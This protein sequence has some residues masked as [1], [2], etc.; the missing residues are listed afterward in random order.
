M[1]SNLVLTP[2]S[3]GLTIRGEQTLAN[4]T[5][6]SNFLGSS[7]PNPSYAGQWWIDTSSVNPNLWQRDLNNLNWILMGTYTYNSGNN[8]YSFLA[9]GSSGGGGGGGSTMITLSGVVAGSGT[10][11]ISTTAGSGYYMPTTTDQT[12][13]NN[14][15]SALGY[16][17]VNKAGD[18]LTGTINLIDTNVYITRLGT[19]LLA[20]NLAGGTNVCGVTAS[21]VANG[22][23]DGSVWHQVNT[24]HTTA[25][26]YVDGS[27]FWYTT[28]AAG[29]ATFSAWDA[30]YNVLHSGNFVAGSN[31]VA[32][33]QS[34]IISALGYT[35]I[36]STAINGVSGVCPLDANRLVPLSN[37]PSSLTGGVSYQGFW[38]PSTNTPTLSDATGTN[39][40]MY[41]ASAN[42]AGP[43]SGLTDSSMVNFAVGDTV[44]F[45]GNSHKWQHNSG[46][47]ASV[48][49]VNGATGA[50]TVNAISQLVGDVTT[51]AAIGSQS[52]TA[53]LPTVNSNVGSFNT[54]TVN[55]KG[56]VTSASNTPYLTSNQTI[57]LNGVITGSGTS[58]ITTSAGSGYYFPT[59]TDQTNWNNKQSALGYTPLNPNNNLS[60]ITNAQTAL[61]NLTNVASA[62]NGYVL[63]KDAGT[64][65]VLW[66]AQ[67]GG[68]GGGG[69]FVVTLAGILSG[70][71]TLSSGAGTLTASAA[72]GYYFPTTTDQ[73][74][75][76]AKQAALGYTPLRPSN[77]LSDVLSPSQSLANLGG[78][79]T[80]IRQTI[81]Q[82]PVGTN[83]LPNYFSNSGLTL[84]GSFTAA[85]PFIATS[86]NGFNTSGSVPTSV[87][88][89]IYYNASQT[90]NLNANQLQ[91]V[92]AGQG[93]MVTWG[94]NYVGLASTPP[95]NPATNTIYFDT[96]KQ[97]TYQWSGTTWNALTGYL[98]V[99][100]IT[101]NASTVTTIQYMP[102]CNQGYNANEIQTVG[103]PY[104]V[105][106]GN[107]VSNNG[108]PSF[109]TS[110]SSTS[111]NLLASTVHL[112][113]THS[114]GIQE[115]YMADL[116]ITGLNKAGGTVTSLTGGS[117]SNFPNG[118]LLN[119]Y[120][121]DYNNSSNYFMQLLNSH[122][123][124]IGDNPTLSDIV[125]RPRPIL[126]LNQCHFGSSGQAF[127]TT[128]GTAAAA[129]CAQCD[130][131]VFN[132][133]ND[134]SVVSS[135]AVTQHLAAQTT[136]LN[137]QVVNGGITR[138]DP[139]YPTVSGGI[140]Q[141]LPYC[142]GEGVQLSTDNTTWWNTVTN[143][144]WWATSGGASSYVA[145]SGYATSARRI[146]NHMN[147]AFRT[148]FAT[149]MNTY[150]YANS[151]P[152]VFFDNWTSGTSTSFTPALPWDSGCA[153]TG[154]DLSSS[155]AQTG[156]AVLS[157]IGGK[158]NLFI[159]SNGSKCWFMASGISN[160]PTPYS[161]KGYTSAGGAC[162]ARMIESPNSRIGSQTGNSQN[163]AQE[164]LYLQDNAYNVS[165]SLNE[166]NNL[167]LWSTYAGTGTTSWNDDARA[168]LLSDFIIHL[169][170]DDG[171]NLT[172]QLASDITTASK[173]GYPMEPYSNAIT[174][175]GG[176]K[177]GIYYR[178][179]THG[180]VIVNT[181]TTAQS[182]TFGPVQTITG[183]TTT[184][185]TTVTGLSTTGNVLV[186][187]SIYGSNIP[188]NTYIVSVNT[189]NSSLVMSNPATG[190]GSIS[191]QNGLPDMTLYS[192][193]KGGA[194]IATQTVSLSAYTFSGTGAA[195][196]YY[197]VTPPESVISSSGSSTTAT[198]VTSVPHNLQTGDY[199]T[200]A[201][202]VT[203]PTTV[204]GTFPITVTNSTTFTYT[205]SASLSGSASGTITY[206]VKYIILK[207][208]GNNTPVATTNAVT[209][210]YSAPLNPR[211]GDY[212]TNI[213]VVPYQSY[214]YNG[215]SWVPY[216]FMKLG[217]AVI[218]SGTMTSVTSYAFNGKYISTVQAIPAAN[219]SLTLAHN[220]GG[221]Q[222]QIRW[223]L[224]CTA[225]DAATGYQ[226]GDY[227]DV[228][229][230]TGTS[231][232]YLNYFTVSNTATTSTI[233]AN[234]YVT[235]E[236]VPKAGGASTS[237][238]SANN[239]GLQLIAQRYF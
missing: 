196:M 129:V 138:P 131:G 220:V 209:E 141:Y 43:I 1:Q 217:E 90:V 102:I 6:A 46:G 215:T 64:G 24:S 8:T 70:G 155:M 140:F 3:S 234:N 42:Y 180:M 219:A 19:Q 83:G 116:T 76:N 87:D 84:T 188:P 16:T 218:T 191:I 48:V 47:A 30:A 232:G 189:G 17:P 149:Q 45:N 71:G 233:S 211:S 93:G 205:M 56:L 41:Y 159:A 128:I 162:C 163:V 38:N 154:W 156:S 105:N 44:I 231:D 117:A 39:G 63:T 160:N 37:L 10:T 199:V 27:N 57:T 125:T 121:I 12:N 186:N 7:A 157:A 94:T 65:N 50:V 238:T 13:W 15:Q 224:V 183:T 111:I 113:L 106:I 184:G 18:T 207:I 236:L 28:K 96:I 225:N 164:V 151:F 25:S 92:A 100:L 228:A 66:A 69:S 142:K 21:A 51:S 35:P 227:I 120:G 168:A 172:A 221:T 153:Q 146:Y 91:T 89:M 108:Y 118:A 127:G 193:T 77:N 170:G 165:N 226:V 122:P 123:A 208:K 214:I 192:L 109:L 114:D 97:V 74:N 179:Y 72:S 59:T 176:Y 178:R 99:A 194:A 86:A 98:P 202:S 31:Y 230:V 53:T 4:Q 166:M 134:F 103:I 210:S 145:Y 139:W 9:V 126:S 79:I 148:S 73:S 49:S 204:N 34:A 197:L 132:Y 110:A 67:T 223:M 101:T 190:N 222:I 33:N 52:I 195:K 185:S 174:V 213:G 58:S 60:D 167:L 112:Y 36:N 61:N 54:L 212:W 62:T 68:G 229:S 206:S 88:Y 81:L 177:S 82:A 130:F 75:W 20:N 40:Y 119:K 2:N 161:A 29:N 173:I 147:S 144:N 158:S 95:L 124:W 216:T 133:A 181:A 182:T 11:A 203:N 78:I 23:Y 198:V 32:P 239:F 235:W 80:S 135:D 5:L 152:G 115:S 136:V 237:P 187:D 22:W 14:K 175:T 171:A 150:I 143:N 104:S 137:N 201:G 107:T 169:N 85:N 55:A 200:I 26:V